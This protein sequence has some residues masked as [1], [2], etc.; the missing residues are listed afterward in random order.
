MN[1][2]PYIYLQIIGVASK[3]QGQGFGGKLIRA[4][5][6]RSEQHGK[7]IYLETETED[8]VKL[9][10]RFGFKVIKKV[11]LVGINLPMWEMVREPETGN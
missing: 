7:Y 11:S 5:I 10:E 2:K 4:L 3:F 9:Y 6:E 8:N 1:G